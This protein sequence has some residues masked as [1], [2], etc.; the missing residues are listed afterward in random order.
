MSDVI[1]AAAIAGGVGLLSNIPT[2]LSARR[3]AYVEL[4]RL[5]EESE[6]LREQHREAERQNRQG[7]Y[8]RVLAALDRFDMI[9]TGAPFTTDEFDQLWDGYNALAG[10]VLL[11]GATSVRERMQPVSRLLQEI[12]AEVAE[13]SVEDQAQAFGKAYLPR[14]GEMLS[15]QARLIEAMREDVTRGLLPASSE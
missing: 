11:F 1:W 4:A 2:Y 14:R 10:G 15:A 9:A 7:T 5:R 6:R 12:R 8:H 3:T 13:S